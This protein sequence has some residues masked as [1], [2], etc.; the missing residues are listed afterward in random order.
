MKPGANAIGSLLP[1]FCFS[2][3]NGSPP[4]RT[5]RT[6]CRRPLCAFGRNIPAPHGNTTRCST[7]QCGP[8]RSIPC[9]GKS[10]APSGRMNP[11]PEC[12]ARETRFLISPWSGLNSRWPWTAPSASFRTTSAK[13]SCSSSGVTSLF[14]KSPTASARRSTRWL[15]ATAMPSNVCANG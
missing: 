13:S 3:A 5:L 12:R 9:A 4:W 2:P 8:S 10:A 15:P 1:G 11:S 6:W 7:P 14:S